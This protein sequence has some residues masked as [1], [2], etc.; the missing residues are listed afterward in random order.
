MTRSFAASLRL[1]AV[2]LALLVVP[3]LAFAQAP[4]APP[5]IPAPQ[6]EIVPAPPPGPVAMV[7]RPGHWH[8]DGV[9]YVW[10]PG[11]YV[12]APYPAAVWVEGHWVLRHHGWVWVG[13]HWGR[14]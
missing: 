1:A 10:L 13:G 11:R 2:M 8:W 4:P 3:S 6:V 14:A 12:R 7:W 5:V 9:R